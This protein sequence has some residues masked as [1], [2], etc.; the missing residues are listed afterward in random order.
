MVQPKN[1]TGEKPMVATKNRTKPPH[2]YEAVMEAAQSYIAEHRPRV[3]GPDD[4]DKLL[5]PVFDTLEQEEFHA[6][7][8]NTKH[9]VIRDIA[10][11][12]GLVDRAQ[13]H[14]RE[15]FREAI[16]EN[17]T[18]IILAHNHP[19]GDATP[20]SQDIACTRS[21]VEAG[22]IVGIEVVDHVIIAPR[23]RRLSF[24]QENLL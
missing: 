12:R 19:S 17:C 23:C 20:S 24:R 21:L 14:A 2:R 8:L 6:L 3:Q 18:R 15:V 13:V 4:V 10:V 7:L 1:H 16:R 5:R 22:K 11:T 9:G